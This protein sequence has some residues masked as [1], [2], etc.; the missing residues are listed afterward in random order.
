MGHVNF[1]DAVIND[2]HTSV[3]VCGPVDWTTM[4][5]PGADGITPDPEKGDNPLAEFRVTNVELRFGEGVFAR[6]K[7]VG[8]LLTQGN[9]N[10]SV[11][12]EVVGAIDPGAFEAGAV[13]ATGTGGEGKPWS[14]SIRLQGLRSP[15]GS[16]S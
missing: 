11:V 6:Q 15:A 14:E 5:G 16:Q 10:W 1:I 2:A 4:Q 7:G 3:M 12:L 8:G 9:S 13:T